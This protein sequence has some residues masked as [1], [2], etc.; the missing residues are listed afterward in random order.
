MRTKTIAVKF[1]ETE[2]KQVHILAVKSGLPVSTY[3]RYLAVKN[4]G[5]VKS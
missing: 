5:E 4:S 1:D 3:L 2:Y